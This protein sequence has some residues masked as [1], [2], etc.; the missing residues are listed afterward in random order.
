MSERANRSGHADRHNP[1][2]V[3]EAA[4]RFRLTLSPAW[5]AARNVATDGSIFGVGFRMGSEAPE[6]TD[7]V[8]GILAKPQV[9]DSGPNNTGCVTMPHTNVAV[10]HVE[11]AQA[12][13]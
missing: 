12:A 7:N 8:R 2:V 5:I 9:Q 11:C 4:A 10:A 1:A 13:I 6:G 3:D